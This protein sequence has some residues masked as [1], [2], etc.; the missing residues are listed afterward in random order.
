ML[1]ELLRLY[2]AIGAILPH[3]S[4]FGTALLAGC[5]LALLIHCLQQSLRT[6]KEWTLIRSKKPRRLR[7][8]SDKDE[9]SR[10]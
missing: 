8:Y 2:G 6:Y 3:D 1:T 4:F 10:K 5:F 9:Q 7:N